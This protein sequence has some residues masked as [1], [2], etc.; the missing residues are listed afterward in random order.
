M[1]MY[2]IRR[3]KY[4]QIRVTKTCSVCTVASCPH[5]SLDGNVRT[6]VHAYRI[7]E[8]M[9]VNISR[10]MYTYVCVMRIRVQNIGGRVIKRERGGRDTYSDRGVGGE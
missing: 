8:C 7:Y 5:S 10:C 6:C 9:C 1:N 3:S 4:M 2:L